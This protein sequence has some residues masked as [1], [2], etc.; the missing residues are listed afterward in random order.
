MAKADALTDVTGT[1]PLDDAAAVAAACER[2]LARDG[3]G[4]DR[5]LLHA[6]FAFAGDL[7]AGRHPGYLACDMPYHDLRHSLDASLTMARL[8]DGCRASG[9]ADA[10]A[11]DAS[12]RLAARAA[13]AA[14][15]HRLPAPPRRSGD[16]R[17]RARDV[18][19][20]AQRSA[21]RR[22]IS[23]APRSRGTPGS[24]R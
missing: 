2:I 16:A 4:W 18:A 13:R 19:R 7:F 12:S 21:S 17:T 9:G 23:P 14:A 11:L 15:R 20:S 6:S 10:L 24:R 3:E 1:V 22:P 5:D 8:V